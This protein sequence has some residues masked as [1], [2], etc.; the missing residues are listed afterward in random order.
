MVN[1]SN[2]LY[3]PANPDARRTICVGGPVFVFFSL[4]VSRS[5]SPSLPYS[6]FTNKFELAGFCG[7]LVGALATAAVLLATR[8][9]V[10]RTRTIRRAVRGRRSRSRR[11]ARASS[12]PEGGSGL[13]MGHG[14]Q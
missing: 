12:G 3:E 10:Q 13:Q 11:A 1:C 7:P 5:H 6:L 4:Y 8:F 9:S 2:H 14:G